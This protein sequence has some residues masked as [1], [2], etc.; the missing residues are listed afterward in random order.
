MPARGPGGTHA[1][2]RSPSAV[3]FAVSWQSRLL[4][5]LLCSPGIGRAV[6]LQAGRLLCVLAQLLYEM[7]NPTLS[8]CPSSLSNTAQLGV[9]QGHARWVLVMLVTFCKTHLVFLIAPLS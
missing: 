3:P 7:D 5:A 2:A 8:S 6:M 4:P 9:P 1:S